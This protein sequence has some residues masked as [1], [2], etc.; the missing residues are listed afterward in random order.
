MFSAFKTLTGQRVT[1]ELK[2]DLAIEGTLKSVDQF[3][4]FRLDDIKVLDEASY[5]HMVRRTPP[6]LTRWPSSRR[7]YVVLSCA[8][9]ASPRLL[10]TH[11]V[12]KTLRGGVCAL[13]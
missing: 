3:L 4:N 1:V 2:N 9:C 10:L 8:M 11:N 7:S 12:S 13:C 6:I 5:P